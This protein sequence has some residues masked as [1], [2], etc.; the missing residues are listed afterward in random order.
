M[1][2]TEVSKLLAN[3][4]NQEHYILELM[5]KLYK[6]AYEKGKS[7]VLNM[8]GVVR[9]SEQL[10]EKHTPNFKEWIELMGY[11]EKDEKWYN[12]H[13]YLRA[14]QRLLIKYDSIKSDL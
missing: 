14:Y 5:T 4:V 11:Y 1:K 9:Q 6:V 3:R 7:E 12:R 2:A 13:G 8:R 10:K